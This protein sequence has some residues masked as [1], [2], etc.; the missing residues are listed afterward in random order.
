MVKIGPRKKLFGDTGDGGRLGVTGM[1]DVYAVR[2]VRKAELCNKLCPAFTLCPIMPLAIQPADP[3]RRRCLVKD[4]NIKRIYNNLFVAGHSGIV[5]EMQRGILEY[6]EILRVDGKKMTPEKR[7]LHI[8][9]LNTMLGSLD[10]MIS[11]G[12]GPD[13]GDEAVTIDTGGPV[14]DWEGEP[15]EP[16]DKES[17]EYS[18]LAEGIIDTAHE[19]EEKKRVE[20]KTIK[21][22]FKEEAGVDVRAD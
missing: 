1:G 10:K 9:R 20:K 2:Q 6:G 14:E 18:E 12:G 4:D 22:A 11:K 17:L 7:L 21:E 19:M 3:K 5:E 16:E 8:A 13:P 15:L